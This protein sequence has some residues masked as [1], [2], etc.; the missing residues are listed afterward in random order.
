[1]VDSWANGAAMSARAFLL[2]A[3][4]MAIFSACAGSGSFADR[5][6]CNT[7]ANPALSRVVLVRKWNFAGGGAKLPVTDDGQSIG[8]VAANGK[9]CWDRYPG[10]SRL[11]V[12]DWGLQFDAVAG[13][14]HEVSFT[15]HEGFA[16]VQ[17]K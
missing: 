5:D 15:L 13:K 4:A 14:V 9:L 10:K 7:P 2:T 11:I 6:Y 8:W 1:M 12:A 3:P 17:V 16:P